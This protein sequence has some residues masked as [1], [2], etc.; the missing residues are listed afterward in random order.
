MVR[1]LLRERRV[2]AEDRFAEIVIW[3]LPYPVVGSR[4]RFK[5]RMAFVVDE[6][7]VLRFD[8]ETGK[9]DHKHIGAAEVPYGFTSLAQLV[10]DF[11]EEVEKWRPRTR[12]PW[13]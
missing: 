10:T 2:V 8:N 1:L 6:I 5:Y 7:C 4:H 9:G 11:W 12:S 13:A 3:E